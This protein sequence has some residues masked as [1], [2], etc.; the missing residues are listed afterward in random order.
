MSSR[1][2][3]RG[4][5]SSGRGSSLKTSPPSSLSR[6]PPSALSVWPPRARTRV[7]MRSEPSRPGSQMGNAPCRVT[8]TGTVKDFSPKWERS[9]WW[10]GSVSSVSIRLLPS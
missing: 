4:R 7:A 6:R 5:E 8:S 9:R 3:M 10:T 1:A 2:R